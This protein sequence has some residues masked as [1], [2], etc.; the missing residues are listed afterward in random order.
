MNNFVTKFWK[1]TELLIVKFLELK[2]RI[3]GIAV[4]A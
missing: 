4:L 1:L 3:S 2:T